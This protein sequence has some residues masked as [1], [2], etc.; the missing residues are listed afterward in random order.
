ML[1]GSGFDST[2]GVLG[3]VEVLLLRFY[4]IFTLPFVLLGFIARLLRWVFFY[5]EKK[6]FRSSLSQGKKDVAFFLFW[7]NE[8]VLN[9][10]LDF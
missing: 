1:C 5:F 2:L 10:D 7:S 4:W 3:L 9:C 6:G 8:C